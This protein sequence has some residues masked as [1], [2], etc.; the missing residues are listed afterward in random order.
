MGT[1]RRA[2]AAKPIF[3]IHTGQT[4]PPEPAARPAAEAPEGIDVQDDQHERQD[5]PGGAREQRRGEERQGARKPGGG[6]PPRSAPPLP[7][8]HVD[9]DREDEEQPSE[10]GPA[11]A[12]PGD[13]LHSKRVHGEGQCRHRRPDPHACALVPRL[14]AQRVTEEAAGQRH[15]REGRHRVQEQAREVVAR[16]G[17][18][19]QR[20]VEAIAHPRDRHVLAQPVRRPGAPEPVLPGTPVRRRCR[21]T[22]G[23]RPSSRSRSGRRAGRR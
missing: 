7:S 21:G 6:N 23:S 9:E 4:R 2:S 14:G 11:R 10:H 18:V 20:P 12:H 17:V 8:D 19:P 3:S 5:E 15:H 16:R 1:V 22:S 13:G